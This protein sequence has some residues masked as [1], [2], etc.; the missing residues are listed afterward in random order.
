[1]RK[2]CQWRMQQTPSAPPS[3]NDL[4]ITG[5]YVQPLIPG[6]N[7]T[8]AYM[9]INNQTDKTYVLIGADSPMAQ[10][11]QLHSVTM[12]EG[13]MKMRPV[14]SITILPKQQLILQPGDFHVMLMNVNTDLTKDTLVQICL[15]F[16]DSD[17]ECVNAPVEDKRTDQHQ[18]H[19]H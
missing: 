17:T 7:N 14:E 13:M 15:E 11:T 2:V 6:Q 3:N 16:K 9:K 10:S 1:M 5:A 19:N 18:H 8:A 4:T 12:Q